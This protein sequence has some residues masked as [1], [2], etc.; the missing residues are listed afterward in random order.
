MN[1]NDGKTESAAGLYSRVGLDE[2]LHTDNFH[3]S[4]ACIG[5]GHCATICPAYA[6][7]M[8]EPASG[9]KKDRRPT[10]VKHDCFMCFGC[11]R[12]CPKAA[13]RYGD[14]GDEHKAASQPAKKSA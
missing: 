10:W 2:V 5:C 14:I 6:I 11:M 9:K 13:I 7:E 12:L 8:S 4:D 1:A 3:V